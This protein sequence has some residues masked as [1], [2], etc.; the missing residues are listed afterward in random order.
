[1]RSVVLLSLLPVLALAA[2]GH[3]AL[4]SYIGQVPSPPRDAREAYGLA[5]LKAEPSGSRFAPPPVYADL[6]RRLADE[7]RRAGV[8]TATTLPDAVTDAA[9]AQALQQQ[10][11]G[12]TPAQ[13]MAWAQQYAAQVSGALQP[14]ASSP[15]DRAVLAL[16]EQRQRSVMV[17]G[18]R[19]R[20]LQQDAAITWQR[21]EA[22]HRRIGEAE[23]NTL[24]STAPQ[25]SPG[26][27][28]DRA[29]LAVHERFAQQHLDALR[30][31]LIEGQG[32]FEQQ[33]VLASDDAGFADSLAG[34]MQ[35]VAAMP[36]RQDYAAAQQDAIR[37][38]SALSSLSWQLH[39]HA[40][41]WWWNKLDQTPV[42][43]CGGA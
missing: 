2:T 15:A 18:E 30:E 7:S 5:V 20:R 4:S 9:S 6:D 32:L 23:R 24:E 8:D 34:R 13:Q 19:E 42:R 3:T 21:W 28:I 12:M 31:E 29:A 33:R 16:L 27:D 41:E 38:L 36:A 11:Q 1:M 35:G 43:R 22:T 14:A 26:T 37:Q 25:C 10:L 17:R 40:A 39:E